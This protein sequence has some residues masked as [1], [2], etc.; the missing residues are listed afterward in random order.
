MPVLAQQANETKEQFEE[1]RTRVHNSFVTSVTVHTTNGVMLTGN[2]ESFLEPDNLPDNIR[3]VF[4]S[5][6]SPLVPLGF[7]PTC[8]IVVF[9]DFTLP[10][11]FNFA[12]LPTLATQNESNF[13]I[14]ADNE[15]WFASTNASLTEFFGTR[16]RHTNWLHGG[17]AYDALLFLLGIPLALWCE[18]HLSQFV[19]PLVRVPTVLKAIFYVYTFLLV[20]ILFRIFFSYSRWVFPKT[21]LQTDR[22]HSP[23]R[24][25]TIWGLFLVPIVAAVIY[26]ILKAFIIQ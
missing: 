25:R 11:P 16:T 5:T 9:L 21:E 20:L 19:E 12:Q 1:R 13:E 3:S 7:K 18:Y 24:H 26:D 17:G 4:F 6:S 22:L 10:P 8:S 2:E 23:F 15:G 14:S